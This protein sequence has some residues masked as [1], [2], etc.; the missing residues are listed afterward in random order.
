M[1][2][3]EVRRFC[4]GN[5]SS[6]VG[7]RLTGEGNFAHGYPHRI[8]SIGWGRLLT[9]TPLAFTDGEGEVNG[10]VIINLG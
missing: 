7:G 9:R 4:L 10:G 3:S 8:Q 5:L 1:K 6:G 2:I